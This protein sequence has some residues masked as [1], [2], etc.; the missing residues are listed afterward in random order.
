MRGYDGQEGAGVTDVEGGS[1][2][3]DKT[4]GVWTSWRASTGLV[5]SW[6][7]AGTGLVQSWY[8]ATLG[9]YGAVQEQ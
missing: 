7:R 3:S 1:D 5:Q 4:G 8:M 6:Y 2:T 9:R